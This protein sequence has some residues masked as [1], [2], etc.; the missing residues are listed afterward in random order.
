MEGRGLFTPTQRYT[1]DDDDDHDDDDDDDDNNNNKV[2]LK[3][4]RCGLNSCSSVSDS[5]EYC[6]ESPGSIKANFVTR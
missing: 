3:E 2:N 6:S 4:T 1:R 5:C